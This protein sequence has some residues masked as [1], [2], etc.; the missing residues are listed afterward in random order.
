MAL[1]RTYKRAVFKGKGEKLVIEEVPLKLPEHGEIL[2]KVEACGVCFSDTYT[3]ND[4]KEGG[5]PMCPGHE[6][7]G[8]VAAVG[9]GVSGWK[10]DDRIGAGWHG[11]HDDTCAACRKGWHQMCENR[12]ITGQ[13][14]NGGYAEYCTI[15]PEAAVRIPA[16]VDA[17]KYAPILCAGATVH[18][19]LRHMN[20]P[21]GETVAVQ[22]VGG[23]GHLALQYAARM[24]YRVVAVSRGR[25]KERFARPLGAHEYVDSTAT[26][27]AAAAAGSS[28][29]EGDAGSAL[30]ALGGAR[31]V[32]ATAPTTTTDALVAGLGP[33]GTLL[34]LGR[35]GELALDAARMARDGLSVQGW[36]GGGS[37]R[38]VEDAIA[39]T[40]LQ[41]VFCMV[42]RF[43][44]DQAQEAYDAMLKG[45]VRFRAVIVP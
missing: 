2:V 5:P 14:R 15:R 24:G 21:P 30:K 20:L 27:T 43:S 35:P 34:V 42:Q 8:E 33:F 4:V 16:H 9:E 38:D 3:Q 11:G 23:L 26:A 45:T 29:G 37:A 28:D 22:G 10:V 41:R 1:P 36:P 6:I 40:E 13:T 44:L 32:L 17:A 39:F 19:A 7:I 12:E 18:S 31:L 25:E